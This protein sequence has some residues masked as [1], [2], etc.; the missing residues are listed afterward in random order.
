MGYSGAYATFH[1]DAIMKRSEKPIWLSEMS[2]TGTEKTLD[3]CSHGRWSMHD[4]TH[5]MDVGLICNHA[6]GKK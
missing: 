6:V 3:E 2:C 5:E 4:C 1:A